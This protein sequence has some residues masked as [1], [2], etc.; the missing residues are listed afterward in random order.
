MLKTSI[1]SV[2]F[3]KGLKQLKN[4]ENDLQKSK[5]A[6]YILDLAN[7]EGGLFSKIIQ[8]L[9]T[10][11]DQIETLQNWQDSFDF[12]ITADDVKRIVTK[13]FARDWSE[14]FQ[15]ISEDSF[16]AS[17]GQVNRA[18]MH[19]GEEVAIKVQYPK[20]ADSI[21]QQL[22]L[23]KLL[24]MTENVGPMKKW[25]VEV[26]EYQRMI[27]ET[28][29][30]EL[31]YELE[32]TNQIQ[33]KKSVEELS[34]VR[35]AAIKNELVTQKCYVQ[36]FINGDQLHD[37]IAKWNSSEKKELAEKM[38]FTFIYTVMKGG[39]IHEDS[40]HYNYLFT[41]DREVQVCVLD[42]GQCINVDQNYQKALI[43]LFDSTINENDIDPYGPLVDIGFDSKKLA[44]I[45]SALPLLMRIL[46]EP[47]I[48]DF[49]FDLT[50]WQY[51]E[52]IEKVLGES[53]WW[54]RSAGGVKFFEIMKAFAGIKTM[55]ERLEV[56]INWHQIY[57]KVM[58]LVSDE[59]KTYE[60]K[61]KLDQRYTFQSYG[62][63]IKIQ[64]KKNEQ[65]KVKLALPSRALLDLEEYL[66]PEIQSKLTQRGIDLKKII[67]DKLSTGMLPGDVF[68]LNEDGTE[69]HKEFRVWIE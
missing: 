2:K 65:E 1:N 25:G 10:S 11:P 69:G 43:K 42:F 39:I 8:F 16:S 52:Q 60:S 62:Q 34:F 24:P 56:S 46:L 12:G 38:L 3:A 23:L 28:L 26:G 30:K 40:N 21:K 48:Y 53:K 50:T 17:I 61:H 66:E 35:V 68:Y 32:V 4:A 6:Q 36:E 41:R 55:I 18:L 33:F 37:V 51:K 63:K 54:F 45:H 20:I 49:N 58:G 67:R 13:E 9:G 31:N 29:S 15:L 22:K 64:V 14:I 19:N 57:Q 7:K 59:W 5:A 44:H 27:D 47:F